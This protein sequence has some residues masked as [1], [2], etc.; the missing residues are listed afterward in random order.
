VDPYPDDWCTKRNLSTYTDFSLSHNDEEILSFHDD[1]REF[2]A[3]ID[4]L[5]FVIELASKKM[6]RYKILKIQKPGFWIRLFSK[7]A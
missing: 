3:S 5:P 4:Q 2:F 1:S 7:K 6:L